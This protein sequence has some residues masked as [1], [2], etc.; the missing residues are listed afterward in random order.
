MRKDV[1][2]EQAVILAAGRSTRLGELTQDRPKSMLPVLGKP[3]VVRVM[4]RLREAGVRRFVVVVGENEG[5]V[6]AYLSTS[7]Y[8]GVDVKFAL[9]AIPTGTVDALKLAVPYITGAFLLTAVDNFT[10]LEH[11]HALMDAFDAAPD[12]IATL[13]LIPA[14]PDEIRTSSGVVIEGDLVVAIEEKP[15]EPQGSFASFM[16]YA[17]APRFVDYLAGVKPSARGEREIVSAIQASIEDGHLVNYAT[18]DWRLHLT[19][20]RDLLAINRWFLE[21]DRDTH[22]LSEIPAS[23]HI[24]PPV[25]I[26]PNVTVGPSARIGP[27]VYLESGATVGP[28]AVLQNS[29]VLTGATIP[30]QQ[31]CD[32]QIVAHNVR[33][34]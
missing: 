7:W 22:I 28:R 5:A 34:S 26:D 32:R 14:E 30:A 17:F 27:N 29:I 2:I 18:T 9:Q 16:F 33:I 4:D 12:H 19:T 31:H 1:V 10:T 3:M 20:E 15:A 8:P 24:T 6:A 21:E 11:I 25:R 23:V 13:S